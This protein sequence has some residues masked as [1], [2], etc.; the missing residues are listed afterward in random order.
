MFQH[1]CRYE[2][3]RLLGCEGFQSVGS[4]PLWHLSPRGVQRVAECRHNLFVIFFD[5]QRIVCLM[6]ENFT[7]GSLRQKGMSRLYAHAAL[8]LF[9]RVIP[10]S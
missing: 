7:K 2:G 4:Q 5:R 6:F 9:A 3:V 1:G 8:G 10:N